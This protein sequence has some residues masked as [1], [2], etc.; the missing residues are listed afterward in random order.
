[1]AIESVT[2]AQ[3]ENLIS[4]IE[5]GTA[6][7]NEKLDEELEI[8]DPELRQQ[9]YLVEQLFSAKKDKSDTKST[10]ELPGESDTAQQEDSAEI[11]KE[12]MELYRQEQA[13]MKIE[14]PEGTVRI[15]YES[16]KYARVAIEE[17][18][19]QS[20]EPLV[21]DLDNDGIE[22]T[23]VR[24]GEGVIFDITGD[25]RSEQV[26]WVSP[27]DGLLAY[28]SNGNGVIDNG[29]ELFGDQNGAKNGFEELSRYDETNDK[30]ID[31]N[32]SIFSKLRIWQ[33]ANRNGISESGE[34]HSLDQYGISS[35]EL[36]HDQQKNIVAGNIIDG[37]G[38]YQTAS[39]SGKI[40]EVYLNYF[41]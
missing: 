33:D 25:G 28:D 1:M 6:R 14:T 32:D 22:L 20:Q 17:Q 3:M 16:E 36:T 34:L 38:S 41:G 10:V 30:V 7:A 21:F 23:D 18:Q 31:Y 2:P 9:K 11:S 19:V 40:G 26:S 8:S 24:S 5:S 4:T 37:Y 39:G 29:K 35:V 12:A 27:D 15:R 13:S